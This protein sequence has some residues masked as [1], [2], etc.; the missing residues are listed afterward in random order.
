MGDRGIPDGYRFMHGYVG[1]TLKFVNKNGD[2][3]YNQIHFKSQQG[4]KF[5]TQEDSA[6]KSPD[7]S[8]KDLYEAIQ[9]GDF[10]KWSVEVQTMTAK[11]AEKLWE[12]QKINIFDLTH[13]WPQKQFPLTKV[14]EFT[15]NE[16]PVNYF[17]EIEQVAFNPAH[18][19]PGLE[20]SADPVLQSRL[21]SYPDTHRHRIGVNY[22]QLPVNAPRTSYKFGNFQ[23]DGGMAFFNQG[24]RPNY[25]SSID[26]IQFRARTV[27]LDKT[28]G[29]FTGEAVTFLSEIRP[30]DFNAP[31]VLWQKVFDDGAKE[32]FINNVAGKMEVCPEKEFI[33]RQ[34]AIFREVDPDIATR[35]EQATGV[36]GYD[37]IA[38]MQFNGTHNGFSKDSKVRYAN[39]LDVTKGHSIAE[40]NGAPVTGTHRGQNG[41]NGH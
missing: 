13:V 25:L 14:G 41:V 11:E 35:L 5:I 9:R 23:R 32:R 8:T 26:P 20:P 37:G 30:E 27:D 3:V 1:H 24:A 28:H 18:L 10:P 16:N 4:T 12:E 19:P 2:W 33:K 17:A 40:N 39:G 15:L 34:I 36:K 7:Y 38:N 6:S 31:R 21:F 22:Q 29:H